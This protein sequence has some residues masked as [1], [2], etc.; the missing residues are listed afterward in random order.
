MSN[1][2]C[3]IVSG[4]AQVPKGIALHE[5]KKFIGA[6]LV[7]N[8]ETQI[9]EKAEFTLI[10]TLSNDFLS[11]LVIGYDLHQGIDPLLNKM[12]KLCLM[13]SQGAIIQAVRSAYERFKDN[14]K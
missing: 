11:N 2:S 7:I 5:E 12:K 1:D 9:I 4:H 14:P 3:L 13:P 10:T 6:V 8:K